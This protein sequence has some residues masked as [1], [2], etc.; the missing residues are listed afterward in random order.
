MNQAGFVIEDTVYTDQVTMKMLI[1]HD[2][3]AKFL[4]TVTASSDGKLQPARQEAVWAA[5]LN[6]KYVFFDEPVWKKVASMRVW[7]Y[8]TTVELM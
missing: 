1:R 3:D 8:N 6:G 4:Q 5:E 7:W 2:Q